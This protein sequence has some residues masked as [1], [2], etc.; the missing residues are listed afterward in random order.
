MIADRV[1]TLVLAVA[2]VATP[3]ATAA[4]IGFGGGL[5]VTLSG[6]GSSLATNATYEGETSFDAYH[7][8]FE[9]EGTLVTGL[10]A[11]LRTSLSEA[12]GP[13]VYGAYV[14]ATPWAERDLHAVAGKMPWLIGTWA[15]RS[16]PER[17]PLIGV[18]LMYQL[19]TR[20]PSDAIVPDA[21]SLYR[22]EGTAAAT[23][24]AGGAGS[25]GMRVVEDAW[26]DVGAGIAGSLRPFEFALGLTNGV[27]GAPNPSLDGNS[28]KGLQ[29]RLGLAPLPGVRAGVSA[30]YGA[31][32]PR[33]LDGQL[34]AGR[35]A[36][37]YHQRLL[38]ADAELLAWHVELRSE[39]FHNVWETPTLGDLEAHGG[40]AEAKLTL[41]P[42]LYAAGRYD[43]IRFS[44]AHLS[45]GEAFP[46]N[47]N[48]DRI[49]AGLGF[50]PVRGA[51][52]KAVWQ[53]QR[54]ADEDGSHRS[55]L[56]AVQLALGF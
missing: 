36:D 52:I 3:T 9:A 43:V 42:G 22:I 48:A 4:T 6:R 10:E 28:T 38:M 26:W 19:P 12:V 25:G 14:I 30:A 15:A 45:T 13:R 29:G 41:L 55:D 23:G 11:V 39:A 18:P 47:D 53:H 17:Q 16:E 1:A 7:A 49:E 37:D 20:L 54:L 34:P 32:L 46:W 5:D 56:A 27:P 24:Y 40:Y 31:Y 35:N 2:L 51:V 44:A 50:R 8:R 33:S 21:D